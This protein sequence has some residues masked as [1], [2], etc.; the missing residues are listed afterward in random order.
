VKRILI[1]IL[2]IVALGGIVFVMV[3]DTAPE[4]VR[5]VWQDI[6]GDGAGVRANAGFAE[7]GEEADRI[8]DNFACVRI[9]DKP[10][11]EFSDHR[12]HCIIGE[13]RTARITIYEPVGHEGLTKKVKFTWLDNVQPNAR[14]RNAP[15]HADREEARQ[16][17]RKMS[18]LYL[19][20]H[21]KQLVELFTQ[22]K[23][24][25]VTELPF[26]AVVEFADR[27][28]FKHAVVEIRDGNHNQLAGSEERQ[29]R[30]GYEKC[31]YILGN[32]PPLKGHSIS[33]EPVPERS[34]LFVTYFLKSNKGEQFLCEIHNSG[35]YRIR[36][37]QEQGTAY[38]VLA[39]GNLGGN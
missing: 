7:F 16:V 3:G 13:H 8:E 5:S 17:V 20:G 15:R 24:G 38:Q 28:G 11:D 9:T 19:P 29:G 26:T 25:V 21:E 4:P 35:Y 14:G 27:S 39:H 30:P 31:L 34:D 2:A 32:I 23:S 22:Q 18:A 33:G 37:S 6:F 1:G 36:V 12:R 10:G